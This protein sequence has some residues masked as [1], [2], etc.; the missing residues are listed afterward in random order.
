MHR[1]PNSTRLAAGIT[2]IELITVMLLLGIL[3]V[4]VTTYL[5]LGATMYSEATSVQQVLQ[6]SR[7]ALER[8]TREVRAAVPGSV[9][10]GGNSNNSIN[11]VEFAP[12]AQSGIYRDLPLSPIN[13][14]WI[15]VTTID[16]NWTVKANQRLIVYATEPPH[17]YIL[18]QARSA[19]IAAPAQQNAPD[20]MDGNAHTRRISLL[21]NSSG[22]TTFV[23]E[24]PQKR[25]Y[26]ADQPVSFCRQGNELRRYSN[27]GF[28]TGQPLPPNVAGELMAVGIN[29]GA[30][31]M[32]VY[33]ITSVSLTRSAILHLFW[34]LS[35]AVDVG[36]DLDFNHEIHIP[37]VP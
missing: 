22:K 15:G 16:T 37:N 5:R 20:D 33:N 10:V 26:I 27:Y 14:N 25:F 21:N 34:R 9:R 18:S 4:G 29:N 28:L 35:P 23:T 1:P 17:V 36:Q 31:A 3:A 24:S 11:C 7:F 2:L 6:Q 8:V 30:T 32:F 12:L 19:D 13:R